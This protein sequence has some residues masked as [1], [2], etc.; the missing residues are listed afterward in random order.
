MLGR[1]RADAKHHG[2]IS[3]LNE[4][5]GRRHPTAGGLRIGK[6]LRERD[7]TEPFD[8]NL[9]WDRDGQYFHYL[10][11]WMHALCQAAFLVGDASKWAVELGSV[12]FH[13][14][15][16]RSGSGQVVGVYWKMS[17]DLSR[18]LVPSSGLHDALDGSIT[19]RGD[20]MQV[21]SHRIYERPISMRQSNPDR[22]YVNSGIGQRMTRSD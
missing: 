15:A 7:V 20:C 3:E 14:F 22:W 19:F 4:E 9:E 6:P 10:T 13:G 8:E 12:A 1:Y 18:P 16:R 11:K 17:T 21:P 2:W 5:S